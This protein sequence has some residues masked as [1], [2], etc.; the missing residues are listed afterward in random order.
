MLKQDADM[1]LMIIISDG[2]PNATGYHGD[3]AEDDLKKI[4]SEYTRKGIVVLAAAIGDD[5]DAIKRIYGADRFFDITNLND[6]P[7]TLTMLVKRHV[8][9]S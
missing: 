2:Q 8:L 3:S 5:K 7:K 9:I 6:L 4:V 1:K